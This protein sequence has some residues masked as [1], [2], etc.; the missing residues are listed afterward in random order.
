MLATG[1]RAVSWHLN[2]ETAELLGLLRAENHFYFTS[3]EEERHNAEELKYS[4][5]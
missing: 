3:F 5:P 2:Q 1:N 4:S